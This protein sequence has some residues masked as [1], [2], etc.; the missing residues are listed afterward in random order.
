MAEE[1]MVG[2]ELQFLKLRAK[3]YHV[4]YE[5]INMIFYP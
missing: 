2:G 1:G 4:Q 5:M 3:L